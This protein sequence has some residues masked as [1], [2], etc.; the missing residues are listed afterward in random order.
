MVIWA[1]WLGFIYFSINL[2]LDELNL[3]KK[4]A[5]LN[6]YKSQ[7]KQLYVNIPTQT[8]AGE[9]VVPYFTE[10]LCLLALYHLQWSFIV[11]HGRRLLVILY[12][13]LV[14][15]AHW[16][17]LFWVGLCCVRVLCWLI[18]VLDLL[19]IFFRFAINLSV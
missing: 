1:Y 5:Y 15:V 17:C 10:L 11:L 3:K 8:G 4:L 9:P 13:L 14:T 18:R 12:D 7:F 2:D 6:V 19:T 16:F